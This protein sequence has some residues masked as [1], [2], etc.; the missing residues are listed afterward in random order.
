MAYSSNRV[1]QFGDFGPGF[2][3]HADGGYA[4][5]VRTYAIELTASQDVRDGAPLLL[6]T[7]PANQVRPTVIGDSI[8]Y[9]TFAGFKVNNPSKEQVDSGAQYENGDPVSV[10]KQ[11][12]MVVSCSAAVVAGEAVVMQV[13]GGGLSSAH[14]TGSLATGEFFVPMARWLESAAQG[15]NARISLGFE[16]AHREITGSL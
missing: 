1:K 10:M 11:G 9:H 12:V 4:N 13:N 6:G 2:A 5:H 8:D 16:L 15:A 3:G 7:N 14:A